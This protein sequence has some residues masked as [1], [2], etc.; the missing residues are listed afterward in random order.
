MP[1]NFFSYGFPNCSLGMAVKATIIVSFKSLPYYFLSRRHVSLPSIPGGMLMSIRISLYGSLPC[2]SLLCTFSMAPIP[3][4][5]DSHLR[6][7]KFVSI[8]SYMISMLNAVS[9]TIRIYP[10]F[11]PIG[12]ILVWSYVLSWLVSLPWSLSLP[13]W[14]LDRALLGR[15]SSSPVFLYEL[16]YSLITIGALWLKLASLLIAADF[17]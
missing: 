7:A 4:V 2:Y 3:E 16:I 8:I 12:M 10:Y 14:L 5:A 15:R 17:Y 11:L 1:S 9:S 13:N 6:S